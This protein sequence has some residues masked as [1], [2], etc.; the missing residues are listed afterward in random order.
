MVSRYTDALK[1]DDVLYSF[2]AID[3]QNE[4]RDIVLF[5]NQAMKEV[6]DKAYLETLFALKTETNEYLQ[7]NAATIDKINFIIGFRDGVFINLSTDDNFPVNIGFL[8][9]GKTSYTYSESD[10]GYSSTGSNNAMFKASTED[11][12]EHQKII[13]KYIRASD[14]LTDEF[15]QEIIESTYAERNRRL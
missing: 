7:N 14:E 10:G 8:L 11:Y 5:S 15:I 6:V 13:T 1:I 3:R 2:S 4:A 9:R 12:L